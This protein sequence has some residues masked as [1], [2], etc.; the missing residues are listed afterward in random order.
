LTR[1]ALDIVVRPRR[2]IGRSDA[3]RYIRM[4]NFYFLTNPLN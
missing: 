3:S 4:Y 2:E 1:Q